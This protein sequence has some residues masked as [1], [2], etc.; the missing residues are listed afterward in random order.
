MVMT[1]NA[2][3][4]LTVLSQSCLHTMV[5]PTN[6]YSCKWTRQK[7]QIPQNTTSYCN[8]IYWMKTWCNK[9]WF[10]LYFICWCCTLQ[11]NIKLMRWVIDHHVATESGLA[12]ALSTFGKYSGMPGVHR[13]HFGCHQSE[14]SL[15]LTG[16]RQLSPFRLRQDGKVLKC[17][18]IHHPVTCQ[19]ADARHL[20]ICRH[21]SLMTQLGCTK[22]VKL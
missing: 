16:Q 20:T 4:Q 18:T 6:I 2:C 11:T 17:T 21:V 3:D 19:H 22:H 5:K 9:H 14:L 15:C 13:H 1:L 12:S 10:A 7:S 8:Q